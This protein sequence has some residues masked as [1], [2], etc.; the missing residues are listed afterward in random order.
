MHYCLPEYSNAQERSFDEPRQAK[1]KRFLSPPSKEPGGT[2]PFAFS[3]F[4]TIAHVFA[5]M[6]TLIYW[7]VLVPSGHGGFTPP[8]LPHQHNSTLPDVQSLALSTF[9]GQGTWTSTP[10]MLDS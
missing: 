2:G 9:D 3:L 8:S 4:Y 10:V 5:L 1:V 7:A 6:N